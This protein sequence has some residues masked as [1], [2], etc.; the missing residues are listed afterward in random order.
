DRLH[1]ALEASLE[2][3]RWWLAPNPGKA[4]REPLAMVA[5][6]L[7]DEA[8]PSAPLLRSELL[9]RDRPSSNS[10]AALRELGHAMVARPHDPE[11]GIDGFPAEKGLYLTVLKP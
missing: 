4:R 1:R 10:M 3:A 11:L 8:F 9:Q 7:A 5:S 6:A 2:N